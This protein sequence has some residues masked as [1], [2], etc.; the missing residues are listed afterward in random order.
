MRIIELFYPT[1]NNIKFYSLKLS[2][3]KNISIYDSIEVFKKNIAANPDF[4]HKEITEKIP[5][6]NIITLHNTTGIQSISR[7]KSM[8]KDIKLKKDI[9]SDDG[10][11]NIKLVKTK[12]NKWIIFDGHHT[13]LAYMAIGKR[14]LYEI[15]HMIVKN[16]DKEHVSNDEIIVF[17]GEHKNKIKPEDWKNY[18]INWQ[19]EKQKQLCKRIQN[20]IGELFES[21]KNKIKNGQ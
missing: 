2:H 19:A 4:I 14:F 5:L 18:T 20:N 8:I 12:D 11:P 6:N 16:Q 3:D 7:I 15:P 17:F 21:I 10:F 13:I 9:F 1:E